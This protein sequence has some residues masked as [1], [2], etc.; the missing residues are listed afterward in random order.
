MTT[1]RVEDSWLRRPTRPLLGACRKRRSRAS[2][3]E[4]DL[5]EPDDVV[6]NTVEYYAGK[7][8]NMGLS[9]IPA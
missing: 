8:E 3:W 7:G 5:V 9:G 6:S 1:N 2:R 4:V